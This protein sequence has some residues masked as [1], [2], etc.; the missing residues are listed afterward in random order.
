MTDEE[1]A[2][3]AN[4]IALLEAN[5]KPPTDDEVM[6]VKLAPI[7]LPEDGADEEEETPAAPD[8]GVNFG[9]LDTK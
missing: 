1:R 8:S 5:Y 7:S 4:A 2:E 6:T 9:G 3:L